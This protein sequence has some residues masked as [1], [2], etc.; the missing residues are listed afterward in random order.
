MS[1]ALPTEVLERLTFD[2]FLN[3]INTI[4]KLYGRNCAQKEFE[5]FKHQYYNVSTDVDDNEDVIL[6]IRPTIF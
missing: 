5:K 3:L 6:K 4:F 1:N 2:E